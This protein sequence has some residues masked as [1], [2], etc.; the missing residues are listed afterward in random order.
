MSALDDFNE[1]DLAVLQGIYECFKPP[2]NLKQIKELLL[3]TFWMYLNNDADTF[4][5]KKQYYN[6]I[7]KT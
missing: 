2:E 5:H 6:L 4:T 1:F 7:E 3:G